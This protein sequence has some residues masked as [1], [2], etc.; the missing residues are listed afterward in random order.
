MAPRR[1]R[2]PC[3]TPDPYRPRPARSATRPSRVSRLSVSRYAAAAAVHPGTSG[4]A[5]LHAR[6]RTSSRQA[7]ASSGLQRSA[8]PRK[9]PNMEVLNSYWVGQ[10]GKQKYYEVI[11]VDGHHPLDPER[12]EPRMDGKTRPTAAVPSAARPLQAVRAVG[13]GPRAR[14]PRRPA[15][16]SA[17]TPTRANNLIFFY[18]NGIF[19]KITDAC[20]VP[21]PLG[22]SSAKRLALE[23]RSLGFD[24]IVAPDAK[25]EMVCGVEVVPGAYLAGLSAKDVQSRAKKCRGHR[26]SCLCPRLA[27]MDFIRTVAKHPGRPISCGGFTRADKTRVRPRDGKDRSRQ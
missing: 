11:L 3:R 4:P 22:D 6:G 19:M 13:C 10:D 14:V 26:D 23:A 1:Q 20:V 17:P 12:Q 16:A 7:R 8:L 27:I 2:C 15:R 9:Y 5:G 24:S 18:G 21:Y 25:A